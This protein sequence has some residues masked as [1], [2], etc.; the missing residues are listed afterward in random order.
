M[1]KFPGLLAA[2]ILMT[3]VT[4][5]AL[6][7]ASGPASDPSIFPNNPDA[8]VLYDQLDNAC[9]NATASQNFEAANDAFDCFL[10]D[11]FIIP[12]GEGWSVNQ[13]E[14]DGTYFKGTGPAA[15]VNVWF[16]PD[17]A[18]FPGAV[19]EYTSLATPYV[20]A[21][22]PGDF[23]I[24]LAPAAALTSGAHWLVIQP[25][26]NFTPNGQWGW[27][28]RSVT[29]NL[30]AAWQNP[31]GGFGVCPTW[32]RRAATCA[33]DAPCPDQNFRLSGDR[34]VGTPVAPSTWGAI[35]AIYETD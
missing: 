11:D 31:G 19:A 35:K 13:V 25:N 2:L 28:D 30:G 8:V 24:A 29:S 27:N 14:I 10:G 5:F 33:I 16:Y 21:P 12:A 1:A 32:S 4:S 18:G 9:A 23:I 7:Q 34:Q 26:M 22:N 15:S 6:P 3:P 17:A 20:G